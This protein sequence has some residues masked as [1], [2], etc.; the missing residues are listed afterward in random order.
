[1]NRSWVCVSLALVACGG[2]TQGERRVER[3]PTESAEA[4]PTH[5][6][7]A[8]DE[9]VAVTGIEGSMSSYE[10]NQTMEA[11]T[12]EIAKCHEPRA[13]AVPPLSGRAEFAVA[14]GRE[15]N[16]E[17]VA[18]RAS[19]LG[20][21]ALERCVSEVIRETTFPKPNGGDAKITWTM[22]LEPTRAGAEAEVWDREHITRVIDKHLPDLREE[23]D[24]A[25][26]AA[27]FG[28]TAYVNRRG[29]VVSAGVMAP[30]DT[31][32]ETLDCIVAQLRAWPMPRP[33]HGRFAKVQFALKSAELTLA[34]RR[35]SRR[36]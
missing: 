27:P 35:S 17:D 21:R 24:V 32:P 1:M 34:D 10:V 14:V 30:S 36:K 11:R 8:R 13:R 7:D 18:V 12:A 3:P 5:K 19:D 33:R 15:G 9:A 6:P 2:A 28:V 4:A 25:S 26:R 20:D 22:V 31:S 29:R 16:V 23:C